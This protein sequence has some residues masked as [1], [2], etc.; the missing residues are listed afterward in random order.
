MTT[1]ND[2]SNIFLAATNSNEDYARV[3]AETDYFE[4]L[5]HGW[6]YTLRHL[7]EQFK[8]GVHTISLRKIVPTNNNIN[9]KLAEEN[10]NKTI[11]IRLI[12]YIN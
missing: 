11:S 5:K 7:I 10:N 2:E 12:P 4:P 6:E 1:F 8:Q 3:V 9:N